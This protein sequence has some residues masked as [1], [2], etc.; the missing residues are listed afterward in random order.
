MI[1]IRAEK[2]VLE[3][4]VE[5]TKRGWLKRAKQRTKKLIQLGGYKESSS[6]WGE[7]KEVFFY[8]QG[9]KC[10]YCESNLK[11]LKHGAVESDI[12]HYR[13]K[14]RVTIFPV[15]NDELVYSFSTGDASN[16]GYYWL[17]Y[18]LTNY[19]LCCKTCNTGL[20]ADRFPIA[21]TRGTATLSSAELD[22]LELP[23]LLFPY[24]DDPAEFIDF[25]GASPQV[26]HLNGHLYNR[27]QVTLDFFRLAHVHSREELY[28]E[29]FAVIRE[30][31]VT[32]KR[33][34]SSE[35]LESD[36]ELILAL[37]SP[38][39]EHTACAKA[40]LQLLE[41]NFE[42]AWRIYQEAAKF[43]IKKSQN[44]PLSIT[45]NP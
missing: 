16:N 26:K 22:Q 35:R 11:P 3:D 33:Q 15:S 32:F 31:F 44:T 39:S 36:Q 1:A 9:E 30:L 29:R 34:Y 45:S 38:Q 42:E 24:R 4:L 6:I 37:T 19:A 43:K 13:P 25:F 5:K 7:I 20:K 27:A 41:T 18:D 23:L 2:T 17:A 21:A 14:S 40:Y 12:E 8:L 28:L 10:A